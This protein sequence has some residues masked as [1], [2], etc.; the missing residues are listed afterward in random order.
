[1]TGAPDELSRTH[2]HR[3]DW[4]RQ[5]FAQT[6][7]DR[8]RGPDQFLDQYILSRGSVEDTRTIDMQRKTALTRKFTDLMCV[9]SGERHP[10]TNI[11]C[12]LQADQTCDGVM[13][14]FRPD[15]SEDI[16]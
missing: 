8:I 6:K 10:A 15:G 11:L 1:M 3:A 5:S 2:K 13:D 16:I 12:V 4:R 7:H 9:F 14:I